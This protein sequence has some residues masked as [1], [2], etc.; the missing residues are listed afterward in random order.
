MGLTLSM[1]VRDEEEELKETL[2]SI[3]PFVDDMVILD[4]GS[5]DG[6][7]ELAKQFGA[8]VLEEKWNNSFAH[9]RN[10]CS[11]FVKTEWA[12]MVDGDETLRGSSEYLRGLL[13]NSGKKVAGYAL[14]YFRRPYKHRKTNEVRFRFRGFQNRIWRVNKGWWIGDVHNRLIGAGFMD[15]ILPDK[16]WIECRKRKNLEREKWRREQSLDLVEKA[17]DFEN[18]KEGWLL[19]HFARELIEHKKFHEGYKVADIV[20]KKSYILYNI[21][22]ARRLKA[23]SSLRLENFDDAISLV[24]KNIL[25]NPNF[26][27]DFVILARSLIRKGDIEEAFSWL[28]KAPKKPPD[29]LVLV[30]LRSYEIIAEL[31]EECL[32]LLEGLV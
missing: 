31:K 23:E 30:D 19:L 1:I 29:V 17:V 11:S 28:E 9:L 18:D 27:E 25:E 3:V 10:V 16:V 4:T 14:S 15:V 24:K 6:T 5:K 8:K 7:V 2:E 26:G 20:E 21:Q 22:Y 13:D 32:K 12:I